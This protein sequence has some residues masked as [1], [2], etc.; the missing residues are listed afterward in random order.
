[1]S[2]QTDSDD[3]PGTSVLDYLE[4]W[5]HVP[6]IVAIL[7]MML[8]SRLRAYENFIVDGTV[9]FRG[10]DP[11]YH[12]RETS[13]LLENWP[14][15]LPFEAW[16]GFPFGRQVGHFGT[17][18]DHILAVFIVLGS[19][20]F[21][22]GE[23]GLMRVM[24]VAAPIVGTA[25]AIP[26]YFIARRFVD[27]LSA[28]VAV[29]VLAL[30]PSTFLNVTMVGFPDHQAGEVFFFPLAVLA[31]LAAI[32]VAEREKPV[33]ELVVDQDWDALKRP[34]GY[35]AAAGLAIALYMATWQPGVMMVGFTGIFLVINITS[36]V[37]HGDS[38][39]PVAF[40]GAVSMAVAGLLMVIPLDV[41]SFGVTDYSLTQVLLPLGV[42]A[43]SVLLAFLARQWETRGI[44]V[45]TYPAAVGGLIAASVGVF[46]VA[47]PSAWGTIW[48]NLIRTVGFS[49]GA[50]T[51]TISEAQPPLMR[52]GFAEFVLGQY[53]LAF[54]L[55]LVAILV[56]LARPLVRSDEPRETGYVLASF[57]LIGSV[58]AVP[59][60]YDTVGGVV[61]VSW[62]VIGLAIATALIVGATYLSRYGAEDLYF[63]IWGLCILA[64]A[65]TQRR[66]NYY[67]AIVVAVGAGYTFQLVLDAL[68]LRGKSMIEAGRG[69]EGWQ[70]MTLAAVVL[71]LVA[72]LLFMVT[73]AW[74]AGTNSGPGS[75]VEWDDSL[76]WMNEETPHPG[77]LEGHDNAMDYYGTYERPADGDFD[78][79]EGAYGVQSWWD[80]GHWI[81]T[82]A[83]RIPNANPFQ[84]NADAAANFLLAPSEDR[85]ESVLADQSTEGK[86]TRYV[87]VD[88][89]MVHP[90]SKFGAPVTF[91][92]DGDVSR[93]DF[94]NVVYQPNQ[95][96]GFTPVTQ[97]REQRYYESLMVRLYEYHGSAKNPEP[98]VLDWEETPVQAADGTRTT[99]RT[100]PQ[101][102]NQQ[103]AR[104]FETMADAEA[105][106]ENESGTAQIGGIGSIPSERVAALEQYRLVHAS[107]ASAEQ[108]FN[109]GLRDTP[110]DW[111]KTFEKVPGATIEGEGAEP[112]QEVQAT[113]EMT[114]PDSNETFTYTQYD[115]ADENG[116]YSFRVPY[117]TTG[118]DEY[119]PEN[120]YTNTSI[121]ATGPYS[122]QTGITTTN[123]SITYGVGQ[124]EVTEGQVVGENDSVSTVEL[125]EQTL[126]GGDDESDGTNETDETNG[127]DD[128]STTN[129][130]NGTNG[131]NETNALADEAPTATA[132]VL[133]ASVATSVA[134]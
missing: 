42:A 55:A 54:F 119:G 98:I 53:G 115:T 124:V 129:E 99:I 128:S 102:E 20:L 121:R 3:R 11:W 26:T 9:Y 96:G 48:S 67:L 27:R 23:E 104:S 125:E 83:E 92:D 18:W 35:A 73:P 86:N 41:Y 75:V 71:V 108:Q 8:Y 134:I 58:Y 13:Y 78:Y 14:N 66:F 118:Y 93:T 10:N 77:E 47:L 64:M 29:L 25:V 61:G 109:V 43:G 6:A 116:E 130:T 12:Y 122:V 19:P 74:A 65:F 76:Q 111:V 123:G 31:F 51:R 97:T 46:A 131:T 38:P 80:Y 72:P 117:S 5:Y 85:A 84:Q 120:G 24:L 95:Q 50:Q 30:I 82:R 59:Q 34:T 7:A 113:V 132:G 107:E 22:G 2:D 81:T 56:V 126:L 70:A 36:D 40:A 4:R 21:G 17:L 45:R 112:G 133:V 16:T 127:T 103:F 68:E 110:A 32:G 100:V 105:F 39:E 37:V 101:G 69:I 33:W 15:T 89:Q 88:W 63:V 44:D 62:Q 94:L 1:M 28:V 106:V 60:A 114:Y 87:M 79:P 91:Y 90:N 57:A 52:Q 49:T